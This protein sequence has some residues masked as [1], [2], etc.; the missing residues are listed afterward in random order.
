MVSLIHNRSEITLGWGI[1]SNPKVQN[2][3]KSSNFK[4]KTSFL[5]LKLHIIRLAQ[6][7]WSYTPTRCFYSYTY[8]KTCLAVILAK[9]F[10]LNMLTEKLRV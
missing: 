9:G 1:G 3:K 2:P 5:N 4:K 6:G 8:E 10:F 7:H